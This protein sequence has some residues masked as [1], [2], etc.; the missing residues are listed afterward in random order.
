[1]VVD[2]LGTVVI[3]VVQLSFGTGFRAWKEGAFMKPMR[4]TGL[5]Q[6]PLLEVRS[7]F[8]GW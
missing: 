6:S 7:G 2:R 5:V 4:I 1:V 3:L 8:T